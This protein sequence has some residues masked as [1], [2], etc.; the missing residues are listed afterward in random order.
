MRCKV[1]RIFNVIKRNWDGEKKRDGELIDIEGEEVYMCL[2]LLKL[3][4]VI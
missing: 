1:L 3:I 4:K 2:F